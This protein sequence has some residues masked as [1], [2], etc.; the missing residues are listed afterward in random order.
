MKRFIFIMAMP[1]FFLAGVQALWSQTI[2][3]TGRIID[4]QTGTGITDAAIIV[5]D[6]VF[7]VSDDGRFSIRVT[8]G[9]DPSMR[10]YHKDFQDQTY[11][12]PADKKDN[13]NL[14]PVRLL[15]MGE[16]GASTL[17]Q[18]IPI[19]ELTESDFDDNATGNVS[20]L[21]QASR[22]PFV[23]AAAFQ[24]SAA[25]FRI[26]GLESRYTTVLMN[27]VAANDPENGDVFWSEWAGLNDVIR[28]DENL[29]GIQ[30][31]D[32][33][34]SNIAGITTFDIRAHRQRKQTRLGYAISNRTYRNRIMLTHSTG[35]MKG[36]WALSLSGSRRWANEG[37]IRGTF[38]DGYSYYV[39]LDRRFGENH[40]ISLSVYGAPLKRGRSVAATQEQF[41]IAGTH[42]YNPLWGYQNGRVRNSR[43]IDSHQ[44]TAILRHDWQINRNSKLMTAVS[45][46]TGKYGSSTID[47]ISGR[48]PRAEYYRRWPSGI[49]NPDARDEVTLAMQTDETLRQVDWH[50][51]YEANFYNDQTI[52]NVNGVQGNDISGKLSQYMLSAFRSDP[53]TLQG[54]TVFQT[55]L[56]ERLSVSGGLQG[57]LLTTH[58]YKEALDLL[59]GDF[60]LDIDR[61]SQFDFPDNPE[62]LNN[63]VDRPNRLV[64]VGDKFG[65]DYK[66]HTHNYQGWAQAGYRGKRVD[67]YIGGEL[68]QMAFRREGLVRNGRF[69]N[70]S[71]GD[72]ER[73]Q[74][75]TWRGKGGLVIKL[76][77][78]HFITGG[79][80]AS[81]QAPDLRNSFVNPRWRHDIVPDLP[82]EKVFSSEASYIFN[83]PYFRF[84]ATGYHT[85]IRDQ[86]SVIMFFN[87]L[88]NVFGNY[89][90]RDIQRQHAGT[91]WGLEWKI[92]PSLDFN[93]AAA[94]GQYIYNSRAKATVIR[95]NTGEPLYENR[96]VYMRNFRID[97]TP[98]EA[99]TAGLTYNGRQ[100][101]F[102]NLQV[103]YFRRSFLDFSPDRRTASAVDGVEYGSD[104]WR[105]I[106]DQEELTGGVMVNVFGGK[107]WK[108]N[109]TF[110]YLNVGINNLLNNTNLRT[111]GF[112]Q[113]R[114]DDE[115]RDVTRFPNRYFYAFGLN[116]FVNL[117]LRI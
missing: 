62:I 38:F 87:D 4:Y 83:S 23:R 86:V 48:D 50:H 92:S 68:G 61:F 20:G 59:G 75:T 70:N 47:W 105:R 73:K 49:D 45:Y 10:F 22:D 100:F 15:K 42:Y 41:N 39:G 14:G 117:S 97:G 96:T 35:W 28:P 27:G 30:Y 17:K 32:D 94:I 88:E 81:E 54:R 109:Q 112:E 60:W 65:Y 25:R 64:Y 93:A 1:T 53:T 57:Q 44:P 37:Y 2:E 82:T 76:T 18:D 52:R 98:Q 79:I 80:M 115:S 3:I 46:Q 85:T 78:R 67:G 8:P 71:I 108:I 5:G 58:Y 77:N 110:L 26:R 31:H 103:A 55:N 90:L 29:V 34:L 40:V 6:M 69:P 9:A 72:G 104:Q 114:F 111:G 66:I 99:Y 101:W 13:W 106:I 36:G 95:D 107:S 21:L 33:A 16:T 56:S 43:Y 11:V 51:L 91:E 63:D 12:I 89:I 102:V 74:F 113:L 19:V 24:F 84:K 116:Y 7:P